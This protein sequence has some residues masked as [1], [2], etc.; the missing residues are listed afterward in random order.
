VLKSDGSEPVQLASGSVPIGVLGD[1]TYETYDHPL[2]PD[3]AVLIYSDGAFELVLP[4]GQHGSL[5]DFVDL[6]ARTA[7]TPH[8][9]LDDLVGQLRKRSETGGFDDDCTLVRLTVH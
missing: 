1:I 3:A 9:S 2:H 5:E 8:W 7:R 6:C 4:G